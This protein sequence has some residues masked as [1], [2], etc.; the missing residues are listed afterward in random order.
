MPVAILEKDNYHRTGG[1]ERSLNN[2]VGL[3]GQLDVSLEGTH[4]KCPLCS[5]TWL[6]SF[7]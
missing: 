2:E 4:M 7:L 5:Q 1:I 3:E 6:V